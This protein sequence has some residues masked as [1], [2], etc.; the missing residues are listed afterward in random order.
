M[1]NRANKDL[2]PGRWNFKSYAIL[3]TGNEN[4]KETEKKMESCL[5]FWYFCIKISRFQPIPVFSNLGGLAAPW[6]NRDEDF[7]DPN[8]GSNRRDSGW[9]TCQQM[10]GGQWCKTLKGRQ[11]ISQAIV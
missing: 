7:Q 1:Q 4:P 3:D 5:T 8:P 2:M 9:F 11:V 6:G 10:G